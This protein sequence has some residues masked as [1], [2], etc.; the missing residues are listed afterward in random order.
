MQI[1]DK[2]FL[3]ISIMK[4]YLEK[5][6][7]LIIAWEKWNSENQLVKNAWK[8]RN[9]VLERNS[10]RELTQDQWFALNIWLVNNCNDLQQ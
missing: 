3:S 1:F 5:M 10:T 9:G 6:N 8:I 2:L 7:A 4:K